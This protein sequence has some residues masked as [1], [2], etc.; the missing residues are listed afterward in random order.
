MEAYTTPVDKAT[1]KPS[2]IYKIVTTKSEFLGKYHGRNK[3][4]NL[5]F[6]DQAT[7]RLVV[8]DPKEHITAVYSNE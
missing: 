8:L 2:A 4:E 5:H 3:N 1:L 6:F 7:N